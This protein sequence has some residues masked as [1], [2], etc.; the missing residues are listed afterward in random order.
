MRVREEMTGR[1]GLVEAA[2]TIV[3]DYLSRNQAKY[4]YK[5]TEEE[6]MVS[7]LKKLEIGRPSTAKRCEGC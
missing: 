5:E 3:T 7:T 1:T 6:K 2:G 4:E